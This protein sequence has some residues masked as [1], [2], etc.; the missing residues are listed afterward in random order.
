MALMATDELTKLNI[1]EKCI[2]LHY[3]TWKH[4][5][6]SVSLDKYQNIDYFFPPQYYC[7]LRY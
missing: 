1:L 6:E 5:M 7:W 4:T 3:I 2:Y